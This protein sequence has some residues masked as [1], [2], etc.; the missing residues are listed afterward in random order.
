VLGHKIGGGVER[1]YDRH[2]YT[3]QKGEAWAKLADRI[4]IILA[5]AADTA[6]VVPIGADG[7]ALTSSANSP[8]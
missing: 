6:K 3:K 1:T 2:K 8:N 4:K 7:S 5:G